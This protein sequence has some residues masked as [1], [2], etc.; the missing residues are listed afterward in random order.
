M[1]RSFKNW[2]AKRQAQLLADAYYEY[3]PQHDKT[4]DQSQ[5]KT[6]LYDRLVEW[7]EERP[8]FVAV[9]AGVAFLI[10]LVA[11]WVAPHENGW[12]VLGQSLWEAF[13]VW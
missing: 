9:L 6:S 12:A 5:T 13:F 7:E 2:W 3:N 4:I 1:I 8:L 10:A 11:L